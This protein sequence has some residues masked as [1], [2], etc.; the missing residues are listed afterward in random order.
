MGTDACLA[1]GYQPFDRNSSPCPPTHAPLRSRSIDGQVGGD[2][3]AAAL[4]H[5]VVQYFELILMGHW[6]SAA[7][8]PVCVVINPSR[9]AQFGRKSEV[10]SFIGSGGVVVGGRRSDAYGPVAWQ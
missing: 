5:K 6:L 2:R 9:V 8:S 10:L 4:G 3:K 1:P 7:P